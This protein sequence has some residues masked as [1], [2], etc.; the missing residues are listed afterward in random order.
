MSQVT[1]SAMMLVVALLV[2]V[3]AGIIVAILM[4]LDGKSYAGAA[5]SGIGTSGAVFVGVVAVASQVF[6][7]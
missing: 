1:R 5:L 7:S 4:K 2:A 3:I 6:P